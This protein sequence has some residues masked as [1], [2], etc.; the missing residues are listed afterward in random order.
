MDG[1][2]RHHPHAPTFPC[3]DQPP[4]R[5]FCPAGASGHPPRSG[6]RPHRDVG[7]SLSGWRETPG[8]RGLLVGRDGDA[9]VSSNKQP[10]AANGS[11]PVDPAPRPVRRSFTAE[12]KAAVAAG[13]EA[14]PYGEKSAV[15]RREGTVPFPRAAM[16][17]G[18]QHRHAGRVHEWSRGFSAW[19]G[20]DCAVDCRFPGRA[21][22][23]PPQVELIARLTALGDGQASRGAASPIHWIA[24]RMPDYG[25][26][27]D[28][29]AAWGIRRQRVLEAWSTPH[30]YPGATSSRQEA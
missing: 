7:P 10:P 28:P 30:P 5:L 11:G 15:L 20:L 13:C 24:C 27:R 3:P 14:A 2:C 22:P 19:S 18:P 25:C 12:Y 4:K 29:P 8:D 9:Y 6:C 23:D 1:D 26:Y 16:D 17:P 21:R